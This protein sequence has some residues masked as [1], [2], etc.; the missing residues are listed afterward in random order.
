MCLIS[1]L[2]GYHPK[3]PW[4]CLCPVWFLLAVPVTLIAPPAMPLIVLA[5]L[6]R[7]WRKSSQLPL[8][9]AGLNAVQL[10]FIGINLGEVLRYKRRLLM[11]LVICYYLIALG[12]SYIL[13]AAMQSALDLYIAKAQASQALQIAT[14]EQVQYS[15]S[16]MHYIALYLLALVLTIVVICATTIIALLTT[17]DTSGARVL[18][19]ERI[20]PAVI[21]LLVKNLPGIA[22]ILALMYGVLMTVERYY[23]HYRVIAVEAMV[24]GRTYFDPSIWFLLLRGYLVY[25]FLLS[26][27]LVLIMGCGLLAQSHHSV[28]TPKPGAH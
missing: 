13:G 12:G 14:P 17:P 23:A 28:K 11:V 2:T 16:V 20:V 6:Q 5:F 19:F 27:V 9:A 3:V 22:M 4:W 15:N 1:G 25:A 7:A 24:L 8:D 21:T 18:E 10:R 26:L